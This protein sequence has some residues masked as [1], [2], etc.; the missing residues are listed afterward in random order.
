MDDENK[1][2]VITEN[3]DDASETPFID[4]VKGQKPH[5]FGDVVSKELG[6]M[7]RTGINGLKS[8]NYGDANLGEPE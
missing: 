6:D 1:E 3:E 8:D 7:A 2:T 4:L 5:E